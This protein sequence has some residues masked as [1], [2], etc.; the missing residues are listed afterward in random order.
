MIT[1]AV[2]KLVRM[3]VTCEASQLRDSLLNALEF[4]LKMS[5]G[6]DDKFPCVGERRLTSIE[7]T[8]FTIA[9]YVNPIFSALVDVCCGFSDRLVVKELERLNEIKLQK[10]TSHVIPETDDDVCDNYGVQCE[11]NTLLADSWAACGST[12]TSTS[13]SRRSARS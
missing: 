6:T 2:D 12:L 3:E 5:I 9:S 13:T 10:G 7:P 11:N 4:R 8:E 1:S